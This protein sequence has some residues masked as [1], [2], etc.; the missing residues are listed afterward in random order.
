MAATAPA[1][2][3]PGGVPPKRQLRSE[4]EGTSPGWRSSVI[5]EDVASLGRY[6]ADP[7]GGAHH[8]FRT[9]PDA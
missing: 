1:E 8:A 2:P 4:R 3:L 6:I 5:R 7:E 9:V